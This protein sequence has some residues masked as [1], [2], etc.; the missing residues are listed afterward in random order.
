MLDFYVSEAFKANVKTGKPEQ[1]ATDAS[2]VTVGEGVD[3]GQQ[4]I[5]NLGRYMHIEAQKYGNL[6]KVDIESVINTVQPFVG[7]RKSAAVNALNDYYEHN[8]KRYPNL[9]RA[10]ADFISSAVKHGYTECAAVLFNKNANPKMNFWALPSAVQTTLTDMKY[11][12]YIPSVARHYYRADWEG[13]ADEFENLSSG[14]HSKYKS[15]FHAR[16]NVARCYQGSTPA[17]TG[18]SLCPPKMSVAFNRS[19]WWES[20]QRPRW[21]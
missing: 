14:K 12:S 10:E 16:P 20:Q 21:A 17:Q 7:L 3:L 11:H 1:K 9:A 15:R 18:R 2:G 6:E 5:A 19:I 8:D 4:T 13:A